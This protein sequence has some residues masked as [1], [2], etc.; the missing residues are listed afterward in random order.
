MTLR[1]VMGRPE[2]PRGGDA[3]GRLGSAGTHR[4]HPP[5]GSHIGT[6]NGPDK[7]YHWRKRA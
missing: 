4:S 7:A 6:V 1:S 2:M 5:Y 3:V